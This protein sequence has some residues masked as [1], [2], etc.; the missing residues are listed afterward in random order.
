MKPIGMWGDAGNVQTE[1]GYWNQPNSMI[2]GILCKKFIL[3][4]KIN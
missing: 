1:T 4:I 2:V 3:K